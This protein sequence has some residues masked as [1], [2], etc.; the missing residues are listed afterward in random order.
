VSLNV[1]MAGHVMKRNISVKEKN[2]SRSSTGLCSYDSDFQ[3]VVIMHAE[4]TDN[5]EAAR[6]H[7]APRAERPKARDSRN[8][9]Q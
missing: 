3:T 8:G 4:Q 9:N 6:K 7:S 2:V 5:Y 1:K